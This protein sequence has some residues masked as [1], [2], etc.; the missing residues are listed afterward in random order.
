MDYRSL[1]NKLEAIERG[2]IAE[3]A[4]PYG[5]PYTNPED[6]AKF[7]LLTDKDQEWLTRPVPNDKGGTQPAAPDIND[8][9]ILYRAPNKGKP[10]PAKVA[11]KTNEPLLAKLKQLLE[12]VDKYM[13][14]KAKK[15]GAQG[16]SASTNE[17]IEFKGSIASSLVESFGYQLNEAPAIPAPAPSGAMNAVGKIGGAALKRAAPGVGAYMGVS[18]A[19]DSYKKGDYLGAALNGL[20]GAF[21]LVPGV[22][23]IPAVGF[24]MWQAGREL[25]GATDKFDKPSDGQ[26]GTPPAASTPPTQQSARPG[27]DPK[28]AALQTKLK[29][30]GANLG[31]TGVDGMMGPYTQ[32]AMK[33]FPN[34]KESIEM[35]S[36]AESIKE[37]QNKLAMI[38]SQV[39]A[40]KD[41]A[42]AQS[43]SPEEK[44]MGDLAKQIGG[45]IFK[46]PKTGKEY[47]AF[48]N[49]SNPTVIDVSTGEK[50][51]ASTPELRPT[52]EII[53][54]NNI[55][56]DQ[57]AEY[58]ATAANVLKGIMNIGKNAKFAFNNPQMAKNLTQPAHSLTTKGGRLAGRAGATVARN[59]G[60]TALGVGAA[61]LAGG[62]ATGSAGGNSTPPAPAP[63]GSAGGSSGQS[64]SARP[65]DDEEMKALR[66]QI[67]A[68]I[69]DLSSSQDPAIQKG[70]AD[71]NAKLGV[72]Q[73]ARPATTTTN[74]DGSK[75]SVGADGQVAATN[76]DGTPYV[77]GSNPN[78]PKK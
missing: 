56:E 10:D 74:D 30:A 20:S 50:I 28:I 24:G 2:I 65:E 62:Y 14:L 18:G 16:Q 15:A 76:D 17:S 7:E 61:G 4:M 13:A 11:A 40:P 60:K 1:V 73:G 75:L 51:D 32:A 57:L 3:A 22:G 23:W 45:Q 31:P 77:P 8:E 41:Q 21:S 52:G 6:K 72:S 53:D 66:A 33:Q 35:K 26:A 67:D 47:L 68:L 36:V 63:G 29:A 38:E 42:Q 64:Q 19:V 49:Q 69:K 58:G 54:P 25:S 59:P 48:G 9:I 55:A 43:A 5:N 70:L 37:L 46:Q 34:I 39:D 12:L 71:V 44:Q 78:L 27:G